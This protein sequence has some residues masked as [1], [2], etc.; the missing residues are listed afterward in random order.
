[1]DEVSERSSGEVKLVNQVQIT[2][3]AILSA[4]ACARQVRTSRS[5]QTHVAITAQAPAQMI[6]VSIPR[7][8][9]LLARRHKEE[10]KFYM[11]T[12]VLHLWLHR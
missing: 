8:K 11:T 2:T 7:A 12:P 3:D 4:S 9:H 10:G 6:F 5:F 1:M